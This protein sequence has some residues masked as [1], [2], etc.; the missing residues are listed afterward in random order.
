MWTGPR[1]PR[2]GRQR[3]ELTGWL[4]R[5]R[6]NLRPYIVKSIPSLPLQVAWGQEALGIACAGFHPYSRPGQ[7]P[8][9]GRD[10]APPGQ[11]SHGT[12][13]EVNWEAGWDDAHRTRS[14][15]EGQ[16]SSRAQET[17][18]HAGGNQKGASESGGTRI[19][20]AGARHDGSVRQET[21][22]RPLVRSTVVASG[23]VKHAMGEYRRGLEG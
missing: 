21:S 14:Q 18:E 11:P 7:H 8:A 1:G 16:I 20:E 23:S 15:P 13:D 10:P 22:R 19:T 4:V 3:G 9:P 6:G 12:G 5:G 2:R 17:E